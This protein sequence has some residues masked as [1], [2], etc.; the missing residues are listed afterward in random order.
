VFVDKFR[1][2]NYRNPH[3]YIFI[4]FFWNW[5]TFIRPQP[6]FVI[7]FKSVIFIQPTRVWV[8]T[9]S[10]FFKFLSF[11]IW[12]IF[13]GMILVLLWTAIDDLL[14]TLFDETI[15]FVFFI[16]ILVLTGICIHL[17]HDTSITRRPIIWTYI[18]NRKMS[19]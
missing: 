1:F 3:C 6:I 19:F 16:T 8:I 4:L 13:I 14:E 11:N 10:L 12:L 5:I 9:F 7:S 18:S 15:L 17:T 2:T